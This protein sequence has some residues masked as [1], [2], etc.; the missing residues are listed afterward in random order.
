MLAE[1][2]AGSGH[3][4]LKQQHKIDA[5]AP[6]HPKDDTK[7]EDLGSGHRHVFG[8][9]LGLMQCE[10]RAFNCRW[11]AT[12]SQVGR[13][14]S[15]SIPLSFALQRLELLVPAGRSCSP[16]K[17]SISS[18]TSPLSSNLWAGCRR[19]TFAEGG[20]RFSELESQEDEPESLETPLMACRSLCRSLCTTIFPN[21]QP[22]MPF[23]QTSLP[24]YSLYIPSLLA[25]ML[26][27]HRKTIFSRHK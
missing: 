9:L 12:R 20:R 7:S 22:L 1:R 3:G 8:G 18:I 17:L 26:I 23:G 27:Y 11:L 5:S 19:D 15:E 16:R 6:S 2:D 14:S 10:V 13:M 24:C 21:N 25:I 4:F